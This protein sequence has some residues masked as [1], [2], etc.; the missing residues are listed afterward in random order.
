MLFSPYVSIIQVY[1]I[2]NHV[3]VYMRR[4]VPMHLTQYLYIYMEEKQVINENTQY[5][6]TCA[7]LYHVD[8]NVN[9]CCTISMT[10]HC[11]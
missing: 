10:F 6:H 4:H 9:S 3:S 8:L 11:C 1:I 5:M 2:G 7:C